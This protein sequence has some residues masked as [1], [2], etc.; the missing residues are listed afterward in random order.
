M[1]APL[2]TIT[3]P[4]KSK[5]TST[6]TQQQAASA[7][8]KAVKEA[9]AKKMRKGGAKAGKKLGQFSGLPGGGA[10]GRAMGKSAGAL[11]SRLMGSGEY[12]MSPPVSKNSLFGAGSVST[13]TS[14]GTSTKGVRIQHR[15]FIGDV[16][17]GLT[18]G[19]FINQEYRINPSNGLI[20]PWLA[21]MSPF[22]EE[23][24]FH[25]LVFHF[26]SSTS[27][28]LA[29]GALGTYVMTMAYN[30]TAPKFASKAQAENSD[31]A[32]SERLDRNALY[33][34]ECAEGHMVQPFYYVDTAGSTTPVN[35]T[36]MGLFQ[37]CVAPGSTV[38]ASTVIG[39]LWVTYDVELNRPRL[40]PERSGYFHQTRT[41]AVAATPCGT[42]DTWNKSFGTLSST[43]IGTGGRII[44]LDGAKVADI[45][46]INLAWVGGASVGNCTAPAVV[47]TNCEEYNT[48]LNG[49]SATRTGGAGSVCTNFELTIM[50][51][52]TAY[53]FGNPPRI[54]LGTGGILPSAASVD[55]DINIVANGLDALSL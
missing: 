28:Y 8:A 52:V 40:G 3:H 23:Y 25:G 13:A 49:T 36:D 10:A 11:I 5:K 46:E 14:F 2:W 43:A 1:R 54:T 21:Q 47:Y 12:T 44:S 33:G 16:T 55:I 24:K 22:Y 32:I 19:A 17:T 30:A 37:F 51:K 4:T 31:Y 41:G 9:M 45:Y 48:Y 29:G 6:M 18:A 20:W 35:L 7:I 34:V 27:P 50:L 53:T 38:A 42:V 26:V 15:E 39:E